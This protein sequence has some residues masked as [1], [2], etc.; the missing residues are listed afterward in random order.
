MKVY[1]QSELDFEIASNTRHIE[2]HDGPGRPKPPLFVKG[3]NLSRI[4]VCSH[5]Y[6]CVSGDARVYAYDDSVLEVSDTAEVI[7]YHSSFVIGHDNS[8][9]TFRDHSF[10]TLFDNA[11]GEAAQ[12][13]TVSIRDNAYIEADDDSHVL[14][15]SDSATMTVHSPT[16]KFERR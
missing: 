2:I 6:V 5:A 7:A 15:C 14:I 10:G 3:S 1:S 8:F 12:N 4:E 13:S 9:V 16:V 11:R